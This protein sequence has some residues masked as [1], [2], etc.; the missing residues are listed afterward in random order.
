MY[1]LNENELRTSVA[2]V[3]SPVGWNGGPFYPTLFGGDT[4]RHLTAIIIAS[5]TTGCTRAKPIGPSP[6]S[7]QISSSGL[8]EETLLVWGGGRMVGPRP[9]RELAGPGRNHDRMGSMRPAGAG[10][11]AARRLAR[12]TNWVFGQWRIRS[13]FRPATILH[14][15]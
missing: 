10:G 11:R 15:G 14:P 3:L 4:S 8:W 6:P 13:M 7:L 1:G 9:A 12:R 5:K 2:S